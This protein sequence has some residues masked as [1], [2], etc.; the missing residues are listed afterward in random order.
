MTGSTPA[1]GSAQRRM[2]GLIGV[3]VVALGV[4]VVWGVALPRPGPTSATA[5]QA[6]GPTTA[7]SPVVVVATPTALPPTAP[8]PTPAPTPR[9]VPAPLTGLLVCPEAGLR[10]PIAVMV[11]D[12]AGARPQSGFNAASIVWHAPAEGGVPRYMLIFQ[13]EIPDGVGPIRSARQYFVEWAAEWTAMYVHHGGSPQALDTLRAKG[14]GQWVWNADGF[15]WS[16]TYVWRTEDRIAPHNVY[17]DGE[18][19]RELAARLGAADGPIEPAWSFGPERTRA[20]RPDGG[21]ITVVYPYETITYRYDAATNRYVRYINA[22][23]QPQVDPADGGVVAPTN[24]VVLRMYFG[25]LNDG[26]PNKFRLAARN[27]GKGVAWIATNGRT[28]KGTWSKASPTAP[29]LLFGPDGEPF[30]LTAGQTF[31]QVLPLT[32]GLEV[33]DGDEPRVEVPGQAADPT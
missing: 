4:L 2:P 25:R 32:Y 20:L 5:S 12:A 8:P 33:V 14:S 11:D 9:T 15:R 29:T 30:T 28:V 31:V 1:G 27:V 24:V 19:L 3:A 16:P 17:T 7:F 22:R 6:P 18:H 26:H 21:S 23:E 13:D 10:H